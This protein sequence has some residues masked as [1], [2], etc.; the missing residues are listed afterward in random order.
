MIRNCSMQ[1][2][3]E[4]AQYLAVYAN[5]EDVMCENAN[6]TV[7]WYAKFADVKSA[8]VV[9]HSYEVCLAMLERARFSFGRS[10]CPLG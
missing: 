9:R 6:G 10:C 1:S 8:E 7:V 2:A 3:D 4:M 5:F